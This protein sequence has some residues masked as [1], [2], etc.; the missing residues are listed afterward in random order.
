MYIIALVIIFLTRLRFPPHRSLHSI[1][2]ERYD[3]EGLQVFRAYQ[4]YDLKFR[5]CQAAIDFLQCCQFNELTPKF[6]QLKL[7]SK[8]ISNKNEYVK[9]QKRLLQCEL[10]NKKAAKTSLERE[11]SNAYE[12]IKEV[13]STLDFKHA[14]SAVENS[15]SS[16]LQKIQKTHE[17]KLRNL[18]LPYTYRNLTAKEVIFNLSTY[19]L[20]SEQEDALSLGLDFCF[21]PRSLN[22]NAYFL[23]MEKLYKRLSS[24]GI[25]TGSRDTANLFRTQFK[26]LA[27]ETYYRFRSYSSSFHKKMFASLNQLRKNKDI[28]V[29]KPDKGNGTVILNRSDYDDKMAAILSDKVNF[30]QLDV[31]LYKHIV[32]LERR[33]NRLVDKMVADKVIS[34]S[35]GNE[36]KTRGS[37]PGIM[38]GLPKIHKEGTPMR[39]IVSMTGSFNYKMSRYLVSVLSSLSVNEFSVRDIFAFTEEISRFSNKNYTMASFDVKSLFTNVPVAETS[40]II[41]KK[42]F[43]NDDTIHEG[44]NKNLFAK[45]LKNCVENV[46]LF[47][48]K[49]YEQIEGFPMGSCISPTMANVFMCHHEAQWL[50]NCPTEFRPVLYRRYVD[51]TFLLFRDTKHVS[52][53][54]SYLNQQHSR[55]KFT[56]ENEKEN[57]L[58]FL[59]TRVTKVGTS[60]QT[61][62]YRKPTYTGQGMKFDSA[63]SDKY[64]F[65]LVDC[66]VDRAYKI[67][68]TVTGF[69]MEIK[70]L[71]GFFAANGFNI[72][73]LDRQIFKKLYSIKNPPPTTCTVPKRIIYCKIPFISKWVNKAF[74]KSLSE[75][76]K[77]FF[78]HINL[79]LIFSN[80]FSISRMFPFKDH[81]PK[82]VRSN[83]V[84]QYH[85][86]ICNSMYIGE[87]SRHYATRIAEHKGVSPLTGAPMARINSHIYDHFVGTGHHIKDA[88]FSI[89]FSREPLDLEISESIAIHEY[90]PDLNDKRSST[91]LNILA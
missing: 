66:L 82:H 72:F 8:N 55:I 19:K 9:F 49:I 35:T 59:D 17:K 30:K 3:C 79:R 28:V 44:L 68:S 63:I 12:E 65:N 38:Y 48:G 15:H 24:C 6:L 78:P 46:F 81:T 51:D 18:G 88:Y 53:F 1:I 76:M 11:R 22:Y 14:I 58:P 64:K 77:E 52:L 21:A 87:T 42:L 26:A 60:F 74:E 29:T 36:I 27:F 16:L 37:R 45:I 54:H 62:S 83:I 69:F 89:L 50:N 80:G 73:A 75:M 25:Y 7:Y 33:N 10:D 4:K 41:L 40:E 90:N 5:K 23:S 56:Y 31:D 39:P 91:P 67:N 86:G 43:P 85:C 32:K 47:G 61:F 57:S 71:K 34:S 84:Y 2:L 13:F 70:R 20:S